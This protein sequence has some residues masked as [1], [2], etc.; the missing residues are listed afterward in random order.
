MSLIVSIE[1]VPE[2]LNTQEWVK[3]VY[4]YACEQAREQAKVLLEKVDKVLMEKRGEGLEVVRS[5]ERG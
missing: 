2:I 1:E 4:E 5:R 3:Q